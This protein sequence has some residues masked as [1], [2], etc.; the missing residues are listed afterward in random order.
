MS[1][2][3]FLFSLLFFCA[4]VTGP[5][6]KELD[7]LALQILWD[8]SPLRPAQVANL[9]GGYLHHATTRGQLRRM[10]SLRLVVSMAEVG[11]D[12]PVPARMARERRYFITLRGLEYVDTEGAMS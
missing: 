6:R 4:W 3:I 1:A 10:E 2:A 12:G 7:I 11:G 9:S 8:N 5:T